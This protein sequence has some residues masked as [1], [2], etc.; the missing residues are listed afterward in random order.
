MS[1]QTP[2]TT[3][4][5]YVVLQPL[6]QSAFMLP[7]EEWNDLK[8]KVSNIA[9]DANAY[10]TL[11][12]VLLGFAGS[13]LLAAVTFH[14]VPPKVCPI[15]T[16]DGKNCAAQEIVSSTP[17][18]VSWML[19]AATATSGSLAFRFGAHQRISQG[20]SRDSVVSDMDRILRRYETPPEGLSSP[21]TPPST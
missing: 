5:K 11:G 10:H 4:R 18:T 13:A 21:L 7:V 3:S 20:R 16:Q 8:A 15:A 19:F 14:L 17:A 9:D 6:E 2:Y 1:E 12:S